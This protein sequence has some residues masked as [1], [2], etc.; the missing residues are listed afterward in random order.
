MNPRDLTL[1]LEYNQWANLRIFRHASRLTPRQLN[2][3]RALNHGSALL[4]L[5]HIAD[6]EWSWRL[7]CQQGAFPGVYLHEKL[8]HTLPALRTFWRDE[9]EQWR[10][11]VA[12]LSE[13]QANQ[14]VQYRWACARPRRRMLW[15]I[16]VH[17]VNHGTQHRSEVAHYLTACGHSPGNMDFTNIL[18]KYLS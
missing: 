9:M 16:I 13:R 12:G 14:K 11:Y 3:P 18:P 15:H 8:P 1:L 7:A 2:A 10:K 17:V 5:F 6:A 4:T